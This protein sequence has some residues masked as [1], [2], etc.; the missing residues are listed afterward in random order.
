MKKSIAVFCAVLM[1]LGSYAALAETVNVEGLP[2]LE[3]TQS[4]TITA[5]E[6]LSGAPYVA[7]EDK[8]VVQRLEKDTN[9]HVEWTQ[10]PQ[11][12]WDERMNIMFASN[13]LPDA[14]IG[15]VDV[16]TN[17]YQLTPLD[18]LIDQY[19]P[20]VK[21]W[22][23][24]HPEYKKALTLEDGHIYSLPIGDEAYTNVFT[25]VMWIN[26]QWLKN[27]GLE[28]PTT[29]EEFYQVLKAFKEQD[30]NGDGDPTNE[31]PFSFCGMKD[32]GNSAK[33]FFGA[34]GL[35][36]NGSYCM[37]KGDKV[38]FPYAE[39]KFFN[40]LQ[41]MNKLYQEGLL[42][43]EAFTQSND[44]YLAKGAT[45]DNLGVI[46]AWS[47]NLVAKSD[48]EL[49][50]A[51]E[52]LILEGPDHDKLINRSYTMGQTEGFVITN[53]CQSPEV[54]LRWY[55]YMNSSMELALEIGRGEE[56][57]YWHWVDKDAQTFMF[58]YENVSA[59][60]PHSIYRAMK[61]FAGVTPALWHIEY[62]DHEVENPNAG[63]TNVML[64][65]NA[66]TNMLPY[67]E[68]TELPKG[69]ANEENLE[70]RAILLAD[71]SNYIDRFIAD[72]VMNGIDEAKWQK[73]LEQVS[74]LHVDEYIGLC[75]EFVD[76]MNAR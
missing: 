22:L 66:V 9:V 23:E 29:T 54:L 73:H 21:A 7:F 25:N 53:K 8:P 27:L 70:N 38:I 39:E 56:N 18:D 43:Q 49:W 36:H 71:I 65:T 68:Y 60:Q 4:F 52:E 31:I 28:K 69:Y 12:S 34:W 74:A 63:F 13:Y 20:H 61:T 2:I 14:I 67:S 75:Q 40:A 72:A 41:Y 64:K 5:K 35:I 76:A 19:A 44:Q 1:L 57:V 50:K 6:P 33:Y 47:P 42:D 46:Y 24:E 15:G 32:Y 11:T 48:P 58:T 55:D 59:D 26:T 30:A 45:G 37:V 17:F 16:A 62:L 10:V 3:T 51:Y